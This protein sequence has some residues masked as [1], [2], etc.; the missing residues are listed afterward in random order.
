[1]GTIETRL[2]RLEHAAQH[3]DAAPWAMIE[4][5]PLGDDQWR[6][7]ADG[8][9]GTKAQHEARHDGPTIYVMLNT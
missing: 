1:M 2:Q 3:D 4:L 6:D 9:E 8:F 7:E 5:R